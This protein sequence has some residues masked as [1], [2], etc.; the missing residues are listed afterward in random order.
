MFLPFLSL[1]DIHNKAIIYDCDQRTCHGF[2]NLTIR[3]H[4]RFNFAFFIAAYKHLG[5]FVKRISLGCLSLAK[6]VKP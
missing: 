4:D 2:P 3:Q 6:D 5:H 1:R